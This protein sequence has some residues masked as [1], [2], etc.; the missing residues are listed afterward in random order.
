MGLVQNSMRSSDGSQ[1]AVH[2]KQG[3]PGRQTGAEKRGE[4]RWLKEKMELSQFS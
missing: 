1:H 2:K 3:T 4:T